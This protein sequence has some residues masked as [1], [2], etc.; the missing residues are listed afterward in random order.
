MKSSLDSNL[1]QTASIKSN[2]LDSR[3]RAPQGRG[4]ES[5]LIKAIFDTAGRPIWSN[6]PLELATF[7]DSR[8]L[9]M[10]MDGYEAAQFVLQ[11][12][13]KRPPKNMDGLEAA[14]HVATSMTEIYRTTGAWSGSAIELWVCA[15]F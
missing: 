14:A 7:D 6:W 15:F 4:L 3:I 12:K 10:C 5:P 11:R 13:L 9:L 8:S 2:E 1:S